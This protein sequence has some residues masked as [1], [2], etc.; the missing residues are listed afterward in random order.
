M[1]CPICGEETERTETLFGVTIKG[2]VMCSC[3]IKEQEEKKR[4]EEN[5]EKQ[6]RLERLFKN[7]LMDS[8]FRKETFKN[9]DK[10]K[11]SKSYYNIALRYCKNFKTIRTEGLGIILQGRP[12]NGKTYLSNCIANYL[13]D[14]FMPVISISINN[15]L[16]RLKQSY[17]RWGQEGEAELIKSITRADLIILDDLGTENPTDWA[18]S[19]VYSIID[20]IYRAKKCLIV[21]T[22]YT[23]QQLREQ[24]GDR[25]ISRL[26]EM[27][28][29]I[30]IK[31][32]SFRES[33]AE[34]NRNKL[35]NL[36][37]EGLI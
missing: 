2:K 8:K 14:T 15:L 9:W 23:L 20:A 32:K 19:K 13:L 29:T 6:D 30:E 7:S 1:K 10:Q 28:T 21:S 24:Y 5:R 3:K 12:G 35:R 34:E 18:I 33:K 11:G 25:T 26:E 31:D 16:D 27:C 22:N 4:I 17:S 37:T 36:I